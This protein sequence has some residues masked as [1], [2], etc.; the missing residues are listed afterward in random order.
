MRT[1][2]SRSD[3]LPKI[4]A[5]RFHLTFWVLLKFRFLGLLQKWKQQ[6]DIGV[7]ETP[8]FTYYVITEAKFRLYEK[9]CR[10]C[11]HF[12]YK[13]ETVSILLLC[14]FCGKNWKTETKSNQKFKW[15]RSANILGKQSDLDFSWNPVVLLQIYFI[16]C[17]SWRLV[18]ES[19][20]LS[21]ILMVTYS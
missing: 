7:F 15:K 8:I 11:S 17:L 19:L 14:N 6:V 18:Q 3:C 21:I 13:N 5:L 2:K 1:L 20:V 9:W 12:F 16:T 4:F 10:Q